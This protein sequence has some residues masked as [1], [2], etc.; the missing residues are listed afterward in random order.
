LI[1]NVRRNRLQVLIAESAMV[2]ERR[3]RPSVGSGWQLTEVRHD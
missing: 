1:S 3:F 2:M